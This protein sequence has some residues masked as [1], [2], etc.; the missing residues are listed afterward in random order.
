MNNEK[1]LRPFLAMEILSKANELEMLGHD[2]CHLEVGEPGALPAPKVIKAVKK[3]L[4]KPQKYTAAKGVIK[5]RQELCKHY[6]SFYNL[7]INPENIIISIGSSAGFTLAFLSALKKGESIAITRP[8][9]PAYLNIIDA[10]GFAPVEIALSQ[11]NHWRLRAKDI[12][13]AYKQNPFSALLFASPANPTGASVCKDEFEEII[14]T[15]NKLNVQLISDEIYHGLEY[16]QKSTCAFEFDTQAI[17]VNSFSKYYCMTGM[18]I[19]WLILPDK[20]IR[21]AEMLQQNMFISAPSLSQIAAIAALKENEYSLIQKK[22]YKKNRDIL[23]KGLKTL[24][25]ENLNITDGAFYIYADVSKFTNDSYEFCHTLLEKAG[26]A[27]TPGA[28]FDREDGHNYVRF[29]FA[30]K[31]KNIENALEKMSAFLHS[32]K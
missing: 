29:S 7:N 17:I 20:L 9:Y 1:N 32:S 24:G 18:R 6:K 10:L 21:K 12:E 5:L 11:K 16:E 19:G 22:S 2:I 27:L 4:L 25:F 31:Q 26:V 30:G 13:I 23:L 8:G 3:A 15:C 28:D 14:K